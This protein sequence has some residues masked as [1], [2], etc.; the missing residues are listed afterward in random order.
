M[1]RV[2][3]ILGL[4]LLVGILIGLW[5]A[6]RARRAARGGDSGYR[7][8]SARRSRPAPR[9]PDDDAE[10]LRGINIDPETGPSAGPDA[11]P[12]PRNGDRT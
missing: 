1:L 5:L 10:F 7:S 3:I 4:V 6:T 12:D 9:G 11:D 2:W 8:D